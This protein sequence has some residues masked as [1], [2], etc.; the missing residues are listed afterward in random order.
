MNYQLEMPV[1]VGGKHKGIGKF[2]TL[3]EITFK[4]P[5]V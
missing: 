1:L 4:Q 2:A 3:P 5:Q